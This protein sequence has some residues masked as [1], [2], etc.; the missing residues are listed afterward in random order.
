MKKLMLL[1]LF[2]PC[3][4]SAQNNNVQKFVKKTLQKD[5]I[6]QDAVVGIYAEDHK[7]KVVARW[8]ENLPLLTASTMK[9]ITAG[10]AIDL[11]GPDFKYTT[12]LAYCGEIKDSTLFGDL[13]IIG[14]G[15][16]TFGSS[17]ELATPIEIVFDRWAEELKRFGIYHIEGNIIADDTYFT[18]ETIP[19]SWSWG[20]IGEPYGSGPSGLTFFENAQ[21]FEVCPGANVGDSAKIIR[22]FP[23]IPDMYYRNSIVT[24]DS[25]RG[26]NTYYFVSDLSK[27]G[28]ISGN[29]GIDRGTAVSTF[30]N[31]FPQLS[32]AWHL[33]DHISK[34]GIKCCGEVLK[35]QDYHSEISSPIVILDTLQSAP[36]HSIIKE[37]LVTSNNLFA[38]TLLKTIGRECTGVG[39]YDSSYVAVSRYLKERGVSERGFTQCDGSGL[40]RQDYVSPKFFSSFYLLMTKSDNFAAYLDAFPFPGMDNSTLKNVLKG[41]NEELKGRIHAKSG[42]LSNVKCYS[43]YV[44]GKNGLI[45]FA[46]LINNYSAYTS[47][48]QPS[49]ERF[50]KELAIY[51]SKK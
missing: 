15:D 34:H 12:S 43:G 30:S 6:F 29:I 9:T 37:T 14:G 40:S 7:G 46:I 42:S 11:L 33:R 39:S 36:L 5:S 24:S 49:L 19:E 50:M 23:T 2:I 3:L 21:Y 13:Y 45:R 16:P 20:N 48:I 27:V 4:L 31:K 35:I 44:E 47:Q 32:C 28:H 18:D 38:E 17:S 22:R 51:G 10:V 25:G 8:N 1:T 26:N 41:E